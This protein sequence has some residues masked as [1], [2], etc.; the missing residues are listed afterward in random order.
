MVPDEG[1]FSKDMGEILNC[2]CV[3]HYDGDMLSF[4]SS[5]G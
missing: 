1:E 3:V 4:Y 2:G 5:R